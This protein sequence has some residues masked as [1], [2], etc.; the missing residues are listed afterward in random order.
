MAWWPRSMDDVLFGIASK[1]R[2]AMRTTWEPRWPNDYWRMAPMSSSRK[3]TDGHNGGDDTC[4]KSLSGRGRPGRPEVAH[5]A[6]KECL[7]QAD[8][9]LYDYLANEALLR[10]TAPQ[11]ERLYV[12]VAAVASI[13]INWKSIVS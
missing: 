10:H 7:E 1:A 12:G 5:A 9:V 3:F 2:Q 13:A 11:A 8:V 4:R 6:W